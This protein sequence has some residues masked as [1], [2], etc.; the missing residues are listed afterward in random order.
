M[1]KEKN[2]TAGTEGKLYLLPGFLEVVTE[3][4]RDCFMPSVNSYMVLF[5]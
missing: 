5:F 2:M 3:H 1:C 4:M